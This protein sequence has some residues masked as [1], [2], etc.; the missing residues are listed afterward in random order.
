MRIFIRDSMHT[1]G[2]RTMTSTRFSLE[3]SSDFVTDLIW[4]SKPSRTDCRNIIKL[5]VSY[6]EIRAMAC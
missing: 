4:S 2:M 3:P 1:K 5:S 6:A